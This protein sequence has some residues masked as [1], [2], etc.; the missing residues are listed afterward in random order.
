MNKFF[1]V[2]TLLGSSVAIAQ[3]TSDEWQREALRLFPEI[4]IRGSKLNAQFLQAV[5]AAKKAR[6]ELFSDPRWPMTIA[7]EVASPSPSMTP[8][9]PGLEPLPGADRPAALNPTPASNSLLQAIDQSVEAKNIPAIIQAC[10]RFTHKQAVFR[11]Y[12]TDAAR[13][14]ASARDALVK[15][16]QAKQQM[17]PEIARIR[18]NAAVSD[19]PNPLKPNDNSNQARA[20]EARARADGLETQA[21]AQIEQAQQGVQATLSS[22]ATL[23][24]RIRESDAKDA[25]EQ[26]EAK[27]NA[28]NQAENERRAVERLK[29]IQLFLASIEEP[30]GRPPFAAKVTEPSYDQTLEFINTKLLQNDW[31]LRFGTKSNKFIVIHPRG[32]YFIDLSALSPEIKYTT[33]GRFY[34]I[35]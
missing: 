16:Q 7:E 1:F 6:P 20:G 13:Q 5:S 15:A 27:A 3:T 12:V 14:I 8:A 2:L 34:R 26:S 4:G 23:V 29:A 10:S 18:R 35:Q 25:R 17:E 22:I 21:N 32:A 9:V 24:R 19:R 31:N 30:E 28:D 33:E 11:A